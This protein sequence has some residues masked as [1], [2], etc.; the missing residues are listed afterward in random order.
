[1]NMLPLLAFLPEEAI[2]LLVVLGGFAIMFQDKRLAGV[3]FTLAGLMIFLPII[4]EP[5]LNMF[6]EWVLSLIML[7]FIVSIPLILL[8]LFIGNEAYHQMVGTL[9]A[10]VVIWILR[11]PF[12]FLGLVIRG[13]RPH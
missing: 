11:L 10:G 12:R 5:F 7:L 6:P 13:L 9:A 3:L 8:R 1:M 2:I 4:I